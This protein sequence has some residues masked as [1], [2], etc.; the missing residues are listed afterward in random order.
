M[1]KSIRRTKM[2]KVEHPY[3]LGIEGKKWVVKVAANGALIVEAC[4]DNAITIIPMGR[5]IALRQGMS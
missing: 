2:H 4:D 1:G 5:F 3:E